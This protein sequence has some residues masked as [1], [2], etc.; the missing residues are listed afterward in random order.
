MIKQDWTLVT[1]MYGK[2]GEVA[3]CSVWGYYLPTNIFAA[4]TVQDIYWKY[5]LQSDKTQI[6]I[7][8]GTELNQNRYVMKNDIKCLKNKRDFD[9][10]LDDVIIFD[11]SAFQRM[12]QKREISNDPSMNKPN[13]QRQIKEI[14]WQR[15]KNVEKENKKLKTEKMQLEKKIK[16]E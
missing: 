3:E 7:L 16:V 8:K 9:A 6:N 2:D 13:T 10:C 12:W 11:T 4:F 14:L 5:E 1:H 15:L